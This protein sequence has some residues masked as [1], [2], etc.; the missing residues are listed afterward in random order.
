MIKGKGQ[1]KFVSCKF[2]TCAL[3]SKFHAVY[4][5]IDLFH[6]F[7]VITLFHSV[8]SVWFITF[9][10]MNHEIVILCRDHTE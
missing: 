2:D 8:H 3:L 4:C 9:I 5:F 7:G 10:C 6:S 1:L